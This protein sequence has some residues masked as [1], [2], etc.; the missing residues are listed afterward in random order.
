MAGDLSVV[1]AEMTYLFR[2]EAWTANEVI[3]RFLDTLRI[4]IDAL[5]KII[6]ALQPLCSVVLGTS[7]FPVTDNVTEK[8]AAFTDTLER[9]RIVSIQ[10]F[11]DCA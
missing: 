8:K 3:P 2:W 7:C 6:E 1:L 10:K 11:S 5:N 4:G 9:I